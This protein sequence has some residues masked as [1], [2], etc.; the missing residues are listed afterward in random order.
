MNI[1]FYC[2]RLSLLLETDGENYLYPSPS[3]TLTCYFSIKFLGF[4]NKVHNT[5]R[6]TLDTIFLTLQMFYKE[7]TPACPYAT[8]FFT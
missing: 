5:S 4:K 2:P 8:F 3:R 1:L 6:L 7:Y